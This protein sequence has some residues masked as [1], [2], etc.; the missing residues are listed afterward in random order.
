MKRTFTLLNLLGIF[1]TLFIVQTNAQVLV[2]PTGDGGFETGSTFAA[3]GWTVVNGTQTNQWY[4]GPVGQNGGTNG[5]YV[6]KDGGVTNTYNEGVAQATHFYRD[7]T[8]PAGQTIMSISFDFRGI[9]EVSTSGLTIYD[10]V[11]VSVV[12]TT[13]VPVAGTALPVANRLGQFY[14]KTAYSATTVGVAVAG[15]TTVRVVFSWVNDGS[16]PIPN[17]PPAGGLDNIS[18][19]T[20]NPMTFTSAATGNWSLGTT[21]VG[22]VAPTSGDN[23]VIADGHTVTVDVTGIACTN[24]T[25]GQGTSGILNYA[26]TPTLLTVNGNMTVSSGANFVGYSGTSGKLLNLFGNLINNGVMDLTYASSALFLSGATTPQTISGTG[27]FTTCNSVRQ[28][29][30]Q[31]PMGGTLSMPMTITGFLVLT[32]GVFNNGTNLTLNNAVAPLCGTATVPAAVQT[33]RSQL[34]SLTNAPTF[35]ATTVYNISYT[36]STLGAIAPINEG[37]EMPTS[38]TINSLIVNN[39]KGVNLTGDLTL[40]AAVTAITLTAG[41]LNLPTAN[42]VL[43]TNS[44]YLGTAGSAASYV[45][46]GSFGLTLSATSNTRTFPVGSN[47][48]SRS[49]VLTGVSS[50]GATTIKAAVSPTIGGTVGTGL[51]GLTTTRRWIVTK[52]GADIIAAAGTIGINYGLDDAFGSVLAADRK[53]AQS[54]TLAGVY[55]N[56]GPSANTSTSILTSSTTALTPGL[57][58][59]TLNAGTSY[60]ALAATTP[61]PTTWDG[62]AATLNWADANNWSNNVIPTCADDVLVVQNVNV[63]VAGDFA[64]KSVYIG[65]NSTFSMTDAAAKLT[66][67]SCGKTDGDNQSFTVDGIYNQTNGRVKVNG[68]VAIASTSTTPAQFNMSGGSLIIDGNDGTLAGSATGDLLNFGASANTLMSINATSGTITIVDPPYSASASNRAVAIALSSGNLNPQTFI[69]NTIQ[70]GDGAS[71]QVGTG[72]GGFIF[73]TYIN[74]RNV[75]LGNVIVNAGSDPLRFVSGTTSGNASD[76]GGNLTVNAGSEVRSVSSKGIGVVGN[77]INNGTISM[78]S[79]TSGAL[80]IGGYNLAGIGTSTPTTSPTISGSGVWRNNIVTASATASINAITT[81]II[82][83]VTL[84]GPLSIGGTLTMTNGNINTTNGLLTVGAGVLPA[85][86]TLATGTI[87]RTGGMIVGPLERVMPNT[88]IAAGS[89][90]ALFPV[91]DGTNY[92]PFNLNYTTAPAAIGTVTT[93][94]KSTNPGT[95]GLPLNAY[96]GINVMTASPTGYWAVTSTTPDGQYTATGDATNFKKSVGS[97]PITDFAN[98]RL[99][100][101]AKNSPFAAEG[102]PTAPT[103]MSAVPLTLLATYGEFAIGGTATAIP[104]ELVYFKG[105]TEG[106]SNR[107][108]WAT[109]T[110]RNTALFV[111]ER[112]KNGAANW[113]TVAEQK[114]KGNSNA[115]LTYDATDANP[116][117]ISYY[118]LKMIDFD[119]KTEYS[120]VVTLIRE[121]GKFGISTVFPVP[122]D[123]LATLE[124][125]A[126]QDQNIALMLTDMTGRVV[127]QQSIAAQKG[128]NN[129]TIDASNLTSG[130]YILSLNN[131]QTKAIS[132]F[133]KQ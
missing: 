63:N 42:T 88:V 51:S 58:L 24:L 130:V 65:L 64:A 108:K 124:F 73:D 36:S 21:W 46:G 8:I 81:D 35:G 45:S 70:F 123:K 26:T 13:T 132:R 120:N 91:G 60:F 16:D 82:G 2:S 14:G 68:R 29:T 34:S 17:I 23:V 1:M 121:S 76:I 98:I 105:N 90:A 126:T 109:A 50:A 107:L 92:M 12:P 79:A 32:N 127:L 93:E 113:I 39:L 83:T 56:I 55:D 67:G 3:N 18:I 22:G 129:H 66:V 78:T 125:E 80:L 85:A 40:T 28:L 25:V 44:A 111:V 43:C 112:S 97:A 128:L 11:S 10:Y 75:R 115:L 133:V 86:G 48:T 118:R 87:T 49:L 104:V 106:S 100:K 5:A 31:N 89:T 7:V 20:R 47:G 71:T 119:G 99:I 122:T 57:N 38:R 74:S 41:P 15:G 54:A 117:T 61:L 94:F 6:S 77:I 103:A 69:G 101:R 102:T 4:V 72:T 37:L 9:G 114:A 33:V 84:T 110:E 30:I 53:V 116:L 62:G 19:S 96:G 131:G 27:N 59:A 95:S 52:T